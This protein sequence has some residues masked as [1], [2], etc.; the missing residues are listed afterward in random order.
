MHILIRYIIF[1]SR[2]E[3][4]GAKIKRK[5]DDEKRKRILELESS[6]KEKTVDG[7][8]KEEENLK[9]QRNVQQL[10]AQIALEKQKRSE[11]YD[12]LKPTW[13]YM[14]KSAKADMKNSMVLAKEHFP[15]GV[16]ERL[17]ETIG[18]NISK[19]IVVPNTE[20]TE[21]KRAVKRFAF[22]NSSEV[23]DERKSGKRHYHAYKTTLFFHFLTTQHHDCNYSTFCKY[24][25]TNVVK[26][27]VAESA[28]CC[29]KQCENP[30]LLFEGLKKSG[31]IPKDEHL[32]VYVN[33][34]LSEDEDTVSE[35]K[36]MLKDLETGEKKN[37]TVVYIQWIKK[38][39]IV[40]KN[41]QERDLWDPDKVPSKV[42]DAAKEMS[43]MFD[44]LSCHLARNKEI[45]YY[46]KKLKED[47]DGETVIMHVDWAEDYKPEVDIH[48]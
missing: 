27:S 37:E 4:T 11:A 23:P 21:L 39:Q 31:Y 26:P 17:R 2:Q 20:E 45:K 3:V 33:A 15:P 46:I 47:I 12:W 43:Q 19:R 25:P 6:L 10:E 44:E 8:K 36:E 41:G 29:C 24:W 32:D 22:D 48:I 38:K 5:N 34:A 42:S 1:R 40:G 13:K 18:V 7:K 14:S 9:L 16:N 30:R 28:R 35:L